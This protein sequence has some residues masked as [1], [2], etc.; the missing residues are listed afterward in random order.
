[1][2]MTILVVL[3][4]IALGLTIIVGL[5]LDLLGLFGNWLIFAAFT[6]FWVVSGFT[7]FGWVG[8]GIMLALAVLGEI[9]ETA[10][11][12][13]GASKF[14]G[15]RGSIVAALVGCLSGAVL[16]TPIFPIIGTLIGA[17]LG[18]FAAAAL[19]DYIKH[20]RQ[21]HEAAWVGVGA[22]LGKVGG[23]FAK[24]FVGFTMLLTA[25]LTY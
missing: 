22:A 18:A 20:E 25:V 1:M 6:I 13:Y 15:S 21:V 4:W 16:G 11:S 8:I 24:T 5:V 7:H 14:G 12:G 19:Y 10:A 9:L 23:L 17:C 2:W 3:G